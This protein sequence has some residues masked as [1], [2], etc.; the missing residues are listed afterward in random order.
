MPMEKGNEIV[1]HKYQLRNQNG[2][3]IL[4]DTFILRGHLIGPTRRK[5]S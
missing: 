1:R 3:N 4:Y 5:F 2:A